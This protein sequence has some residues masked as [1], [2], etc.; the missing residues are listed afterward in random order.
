[1]AGHGVELPSTTLITSAYITVRNM[2]SLSYIFDSHGTTHHALVGFETFG[3]IKLLQPQKLCLAFTAITF[4]L[5]VHYDNIPI[6]WYGIEYK[7]NNY[8]YVLTCHHYK[9]YI[10][11][12]KV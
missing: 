4:E 11:H 3:R 1:V 12:L 9:L 10:S 2:Q 8:H 6:A 7:S 5:W